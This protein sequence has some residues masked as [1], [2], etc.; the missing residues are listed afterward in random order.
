MLH[1]CGAENLNSHCIKKEPHHSTM[2][3][4]M[5]PGH[6]S[7]KLVGRFHSLSEARCAMDHAGRIKRLVRHRSLG[8]PLRRHVRALEEA[9]LRM[10]LEAKALSVRYWRAQGHAFPSPQPAEWPAGWV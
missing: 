7:G 8:R 2:F 3:L 9:A 6:S 1:M 5:L 4:A 10:E